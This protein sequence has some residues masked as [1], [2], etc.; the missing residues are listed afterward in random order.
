MYAQAL[1]ELERTRSVEPSVAVAATGGSLP[2]RI[3]RI[4]GHETSSQDWQSAAA[5]LIFIVVSMAGG[6]W[7]TDTLQALPF[8]PPRPPAP[9]EFA[10]LQALTPALPPVATAIQ[11]IAAIITAQ[12]TLP[13]PEPQQAGPSTSGLIRGTVVRSGSSEPI[14]GA[15]VSLVGGFISPQALQTLLTFFANRGVVV[16]PPTGPPDEKFIQTLIDVAAAR[17]V[18]TGNPQVQ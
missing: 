11:S 7:Q 16:S 13:V 8:Q 9:A 15:Q 2:Q 1:I 14:P 10:A 12:P 4:L 3:R 18:S 6:L 5:A 17:G